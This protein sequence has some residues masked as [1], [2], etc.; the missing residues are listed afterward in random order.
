M[1]Y[2]VMDPHVSII[3]SIVIAII[4]SLRSV[5]LVAMQW[6]VRLLQRIELIDPRYILAVSPN[7]DMQCNNAMMLTGMKFYHN[8]NLLHCI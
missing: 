7:S 6:I 5:R 3:Y 1:V 2:L 4:V 8:V